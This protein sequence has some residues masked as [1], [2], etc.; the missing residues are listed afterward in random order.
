VANGVIPD[1][2]LSRECYRILNNEDTQFQAW[3]LLLWVNNFT[4]DESTT[5]ADLTE[6][7]FSGYSRRALPAAGW[8]TPTVAAHLATSTQAAT[9]VWT[10]GNAGDVTVYGCAYLDVTYNVLRFVQR[11][12]TADIT[13]VNP[14]GTIAVTPTFTYRTQ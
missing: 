8:S 11:F 4:P 14:G 7:S 6:A 3:Q 2:G 10:N 9:Q 5:L 12:D 1:E 13:A